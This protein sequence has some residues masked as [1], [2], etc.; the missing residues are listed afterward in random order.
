LDEERKGARRG[1]AQGG[2]LRLR[3]R[4]GKRGVLGTAAGHLKGHGGGR[5]WRGESSPDAPMRRRSRGP[6]RRL[7][8]AY[9]VGAIVARQRHG[10]AAWPA[11]DRGL[12][13]LTRGPGYYALF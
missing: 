9:A 13:R 3:E 11:Q 2:W 6:G 1:A 4:L 5:E 12:K 10:L 7:R 8:A